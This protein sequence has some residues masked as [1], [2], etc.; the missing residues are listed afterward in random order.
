[1]SCGYNNNN[2]NYKTSIVPISLKIIK[3]SGAPST[4]VGQTHSP[5]MMFIVG[6]MFLMCDTLLL[7]ICSLCPIG[8]IVA[9]LDKLVP[10]YSVAS[11]WSNWKYGWPQ[12]STT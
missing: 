3:L 5:G 7:V 9:L 11:P 2:N 1:M 12:I 6:H 8:S 4:G 10:G